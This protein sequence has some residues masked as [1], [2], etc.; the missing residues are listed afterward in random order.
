MVC[1]FR[2][3]SHHTGSLDSLGE[4]SCVRLTPEH[5]TFETLRAAVYNYSKSVAVVA[6]TQKG[7]EAYLALPERLLPLLSGP[8]RGDR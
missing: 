8:K 4:I 5:M 6:N 2:C 1:V 7:E 3:V